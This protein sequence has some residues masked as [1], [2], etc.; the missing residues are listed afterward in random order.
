[1]SRNPDRRTDRRFPKIVPLCR[2]AGEVITVDGVK[3][4]NVDQ[5]TDLGVQIDH[6]LYFN[7]HINTVSIRAEQRAS[8][9]LKCFHTRESTILSKAFTTDVRPLLEYCCNVW[10]P[11][12]QT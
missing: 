1:M 5:M 8:L 12:G 2:F 6:S 9:I 10:S 4:P 3:L 11:I 7:S